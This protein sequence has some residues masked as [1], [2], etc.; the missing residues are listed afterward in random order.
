[1]PLLLFNKVKSRKL[2][3]A[4]LAYQ[5]QKSPGL[6]DVEGV[7]LVALVAFTGSPEKSPQNC[8]AQASMHIP[9]PNTCFPAIASLRFKL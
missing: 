6:Q 2:S 9:F 1:M 5:S 4:S 8:P 7:A 3:N